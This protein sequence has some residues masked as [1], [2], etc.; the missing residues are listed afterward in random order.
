MWTQG[1]RVKRQRNTPY[2]NGPQ[3]NMHGITLPAEIRDLFFVRIGLG[4]PLTS[5]RLETLFHSNS[6]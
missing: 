3:W 6:R 2:P 1:H 5:W 4:E